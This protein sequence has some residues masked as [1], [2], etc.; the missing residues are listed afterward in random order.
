MPAISTHSDRLFITLCSCYMSMH[1]SDT[2]QSGLA[3]FLD[4]NKSRI[5]INVR[6]KM[7]RYIAY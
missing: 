5:K 7:E 4:K 3:D 2:K 6:N 1:F